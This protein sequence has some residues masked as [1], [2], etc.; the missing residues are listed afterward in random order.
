MPCCWAWMAAV[1]RKIRFLPGTKDEG[2]SSSLP[3]VSS[4][5]WLVRALSVSWEKISSLTVL[6]GTLVVAAI[7]AAASNS[8]WCLWP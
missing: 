6:R 5:S 8:T 2:S 4:L 1:E 7:L 3:G